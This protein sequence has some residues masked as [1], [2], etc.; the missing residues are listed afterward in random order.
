MTDSDER[1]PQEENFEELFRESIIKKDHFSVG[2]EVAGR[3]VFIAGENI[4]I[5]IAGKSEAVIQSAEFADEEGKPRVNPGDDIKAYVVSV[6]GG[7]IHLTTRIGRGQVSPDLLEKARR[8]S[9]PVEGTVLSSVNGGYRVSVS[10][11]E[12][13]CPVSQMDVKPVRD[14]QSILNK[15]LIFKVTQI[16]ERGRNIVLSRRAYLEEY[17]QLREKELRGTL[18]EGDT[19][20]GTVTS[21]QRFG[22]F[23]D[24]GGVEALVPR[25][26][27]SWSRMAGPESFRPG[28]QAKAK[29]LSLDWGEK[30]IVLSMKQLEPEPWGHIARF[31][32]GQEINGKVTNI[33]KSGAFVE[34]APG[35]EG[36]IPISRM[37]LTKRLSRPEEAVSLGAE[38][39]VR[40]MEIRPEE[41]KISLELIT[42]EPDPWQTPS[43]ELMAQVFIAIIESARPNGLGVRLPNGMAGYVPREECAGRKGTDFQTAYASGKDIKVAVKNIDKDKRRLL[44]SELEALRKEELLEYEKY[45]ST[46]GETGVQGTAFGRL[47]KE[48]F[49]EISQ[50]KEPE[51][52]PT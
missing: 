39:N 8:H 6:H 30:R 16:T 29:I 47:F 20:T 22:L 5:D 34:L 50:K 43:G 32:A 11:I 41:R 28:E 40:L 24:L 38:V 35:L 52:P 37:S 15:G 49:E 14:P 18:K 4:F 12:C 3:V 45:R 23:I 44:L 36:F 27:I 13:F 26:E 25:T 1:E 33:I 21:V 48:K 7:E 17:M 2:D 9:I 19:V 46:G 31:R 51:K 10:G 42:G